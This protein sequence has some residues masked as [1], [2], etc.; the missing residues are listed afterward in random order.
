M[1]AITGLVFNRTYL[2]NGRAIGIIYRP[3]LCRFFATDVLWL[4]GAR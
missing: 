2:S 3:S 1:T 4:N